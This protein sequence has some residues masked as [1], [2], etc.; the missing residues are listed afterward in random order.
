[1]DE[2]NGFGSWSGSIA[3]V[4]FSALDLSTA[5]GIA[6]QKIFEAEKFMAERWKA[7]IV[8]ASGSA[9]VAGKCFLGP[10]FLGS[11]WSAAAS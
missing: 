2:D 8:M 11:V 4:N 6:A 3:F 1:M 10:M 7:M 5:T 9:G